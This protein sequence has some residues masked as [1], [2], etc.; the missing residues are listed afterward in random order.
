MMTFFPLPHPR[1]RQMA[2]AWAA[3]LTLV[4]LT[5]AAAPAH[6]EQGGLNLCVKTKKPNRGIVR[7]A[8]TAR[9]CKKDERLVVVAPSAGE[10]GPKG[11]PGAAGPA[12]PVGP[13]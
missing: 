11:D 7:Y 8:E 2:L 3:C 12:G 5:I 6:G 1:L 9:E 4:G 10:A 13:Q